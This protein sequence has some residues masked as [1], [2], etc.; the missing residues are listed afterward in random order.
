VQQTYLRAWQAWTAGRRSG[1]SPGLLICLNLCRDRAGPGGRP[2][3]WR[4]PPTRRRT[5]PTAPTSPPRRSTGSNACR[6]SGRCGRCQRRSRWRHAF[7]TRRVHS[8]RGRQILA[9][10]QPGSGPGAAAPGRRTSGSGDLARMARAAACWVVCRWS[11]TPT[12]TPPAPSRAAPSRPVVPDRVGAHHPA[13]SD[14]GVTQ[15][16]GWD[17]SAPTVPRRHWCSAR[18]TPRCCW[19]PPGS[20]RT[21]TGTRA[22]P[23]RDG[24]APGL[25][26]QL[27]YVMSTVQAARLARV[28]ERRRVGGRDYLAMCEN[29]PRPARVTS[30]AARGRLASTRAARSW[31]TSRP[32]ATRRSPSTQTSATSAGP[33]Q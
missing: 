8:R 22:R 28:Y 14:T 25:P 4:A 26:A 16:D 15:V 29:S 31:P 10:Y 27:R 1:S 21:P 13:G 17:G 7:G 32:D 24:D 5:I 30:S 6:W 11:P 23:E 2:P 12:R 3:A 19:P 33:V 18:T 20:A 9:S